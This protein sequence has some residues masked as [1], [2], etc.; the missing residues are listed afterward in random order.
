M[1]SK[2][3]SKPGYFL[4]AAFLITISF[5]SCS[6]DDVQ[7]GQKTFGIFTVQ[8]DEATVHMNGTIDRKITKTFNQ[9]KTAYPDAKRIVMMDCPGSSDDESNLKVSKEMH[10]LGYE[11]HLT[12]T[13]EIS[14]GA[15]DMY[16]GGKKRT[17]EPGARIGVHSWGTSD[18]DPIATSYPKGHEVHLHYINYYTSVGFTQQQAEDFYYF[19]INAAPAESIHWMTTQE[20][21]KYDVLTK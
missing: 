16:V 11:F 13:S 17:M 21:E 20:I 19:T 6:N 9:L 18:G 15:V 12:A 8:D 3:I 2:I 4:L 14:S 10:D 1:K 5:S 7:E